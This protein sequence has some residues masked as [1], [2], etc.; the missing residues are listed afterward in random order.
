MQS[1]QG[2]LVRSFGFTS[3]F[4]LVVGSVMGSGVFLVASDIAQRV[5]SPLLALSV[6]VVAGL[7]SMIGALIF[8][9]LASLYPKAGGQYVY[10]T[11]A[12]GHLVG[13]L[14][15]WTL[16]LVI[17]SGSV[18]AIAIAFAKF[19]S[20]FWGGAPETYPLIASIAIV[21]LTLLNAAGVKK[22]VGLL[23]GSTSLK[24]GVLAFLSLL[25]FWLAPDALTSSE[26]EMPAAF[27]WSAY[28]VALIAA[29]WAYDGWNNVSFVA[30]EI[31][32]PQRNIPLGYG[33]G[34]AAVTLLYVTA[35]AVY[36]QF[37]T[38]SEIA[39]SSFVAADTAYLLGGTRAKNAMALFVSF[40]AFGC[41][42]AL[43]L[44]GARVIYAMAQSGELPRVFAYVGKRSHS[45]TAALYAQMAWTLVLVWSG[46]YEQ[47][48]TY[49]VFSAFLFYGLTTIALFRLRRT[50]GG[51]KR[52][53]SVPG[54]PWLPLSY[55]LFC[56][57]FAANALIEKPTESVIGLVIV[58][59]GIPAFWLLK[60]KQRHTVVG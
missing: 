51:L 12:F 11:E 18:A 35:N 56:I 10:L 30:S 55:L 16:V 7:F 49:V 19:A 5:S 20:A 23:D 33:A 22:A 4:F 40:S 2:A 45:P 6:W 27:S 39:N 36:Y 31:E 54:Y 25:G 50:A 44:G 24:M 60:Q 41:V 46:S 15:G 1:S 38:P 28:G 42:H 53:F 34:I 48:F 9:E 57:A 14:F 52:L 8:A 58:A 59:F 47:L 21:L 43:I 17:Q 3:T 37:L 13:F 29:F 32:H 26:T